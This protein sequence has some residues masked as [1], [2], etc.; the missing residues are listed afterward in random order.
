MPRRSRLALGLLCLL[1]SGFQG[2]AQASDP[3]GF[4]GKFVWDM[5]DEAFGGFSGIEVQDGGETFFVLGDK[6]VFLSGRFQR[7]GQG[8]VTG[9]SAGAI[10]P[11]IGGRDHK[12]LAGRRSDSE[13][14]AIDAAGNAFVSFEHRARVARLDLDSGIVRDLKRHPDFAGL[15]RNGALEAL[16][17]GPDQ[18][19]YA[20]PE[21]PPTPDFPVYRWADGV[22]D[23]RL[24][25]TRRGT[26]LPVAADIGPDGRFY[27]LERDFR[28]IGGF[29]N[30]LRRFD[31]TE[32][33]LVN[34]VTLIVTP[35]G[36]Y[37]N[38]EGMSVWQDT[39]G[40]LRATMISDDNFF[41][42]QETQIIEFALPD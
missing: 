28:G 40:R 2:S 29:A 41:A 15:P 17:V 25:V 1:L 38:L 16:A 36:W 21:D 23:T 24:S 10:R 22:W 30:R 9:I 11:L 26:F 39:A 13:G 8:R 14:L 6:A 7:D 19:L 32:A 12:P 34:E 5:P 42:L 27:L 33:G 3:P 37:D 18:V 20:L 4:I 35:L 31:L